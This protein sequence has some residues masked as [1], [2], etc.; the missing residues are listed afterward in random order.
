MREKKRKTHRA[1]S[2]A[3]AAFYTLTGWCKPLGGG[4]VA[5]GLPRA[6]RPMQL[7]RGARVQ[8]THLRAYSARTVYFSRL[9]IKGIAQ[10]TVIYTFHSAISALLW[11]SSVQKGHE[12]SQRLIFRRPPHDTRVNSHSHGMAGF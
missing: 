2:P 3:G 9:L 1:R 10:F 4:R 8:P 11:P 6:D 7:S 5:D 12:M